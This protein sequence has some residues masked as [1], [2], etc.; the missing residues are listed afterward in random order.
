[1]EE[2]V[3]VS[4]PCSAVDIVPTLGN[5]FGLEYDSRLL[6]GRDVL[7]QDYDP[8]DAYGSIPLVILPTAAG[9]SW[10]TAA[11]VYE[12]STRTFTANP[13]VTVP[14]GYVN[15]INDR[16]SLQYYYA[17]LLVTYDYYAIALGDR[18]PNAPQLPTPTPAEDMTPEETLEQPD[19]I[20]PET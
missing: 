18:A 14:E 2:A 15:A 6:S 8:A 16:V 3:T 1:M 17:E 5:L 9:N 20:E 10:A 19:Y 13:G 12:S 4:E 11:G 7:D